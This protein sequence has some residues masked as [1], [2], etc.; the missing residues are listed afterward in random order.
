M[1]MKGEGTQCINIEGIKSE[2]EN[3]W[4]EK[5]MKNDKTLQF[6]IKKKCK[7]SR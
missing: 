1:K 4:Q 2:N 7:N 5:K 3:E 6:T